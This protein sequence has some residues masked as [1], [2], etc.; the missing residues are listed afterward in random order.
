MPK[1]YVLIVILLFSFC[2]RAQS[3]NTETVEKK[4]ETKTVNASKS[5]ETESAQTKS[6]E[7][8][9]GEKKSDDTKT[10]SPSKSK[11]T[12]PPE[13][14]IPAKIPKIT[15]S[16]TIDGKIDEEVWAKAAVFKDFYQTNPG[17]NIA[18]S[19]PTEARM[20]YDEKHLYIAFKC[21]D[22]KDKIRA[23]VAKRDDV[24]G[25]DNVR[26][27]LDT[28]NDQRRAYILGFNP[29]GIQMDGI[30][31]E[32]RGSDFSVDIVMES[33]GVIEDWGWSVEVKIPFKSLRYTAGK[34]KMWGFNVAR[35]IDRFNDEFD[36]WMPDDRNIS[37]QLIK[38]GRITG[39]DE[40]KYER[41]LEIVPS[42]TVSET[43][44][45][46]RANEVPGGRF[47]NQPIKQDIGVNLKYTITPNITLDAAYNPDFAEIEADAPVVSANQRFP[48][49]FEEKRPFFL[50]GADIFQTPLQVF[51]SRNII[52]PDFAAK[53]TGKVGKTSFGFLAASDNAPGNYE[54]DDRI[55]QF[56]RPRID[57]FLDK[58]ALFGILRVKRDFGK[59]NNIGFTATYRGFPEQRNVL[60]GF[61][62]RFKLNEKT[63]FQFQAVGTNS[64]RCFFDAEFEPLLN[65]LQ[66]QRNREICGGGTFN[67]TTVLGNP[68][69][70]YRTGNGLAYY[71][72]YDYTEKNRGFQI[73][74]GGR[75]KDYR[76]DAGF[77][78]RQNTNYAFA[79]FRLSTE[80]KPKA[81][82][83][84]ANWFNNVSVNYDWQG[85]S[86]GAEW[87]SNLSFTLQ[88]NTRLN[89]NGGIGYERLFEEEFGLKRMPTRPNG[90]AFFGN[91]E[92]STTNGWLSANF[93]KQI[94][95]KISVGVFAGTIFNAYD[96]DFGA[97]ERFPRV[98]SAFA[99]YLVEE[100]RRR[101][102]GLS[103]LSEPGLDPG[104]GQQ[105][106]FGFE[107]ELKPINPLRMSLEYNKS[108]LVR[109]DTGRI[110][111]DA[112][113]VT[114]RS[115]YQFT[116]F[117]F[118]RTRL[119][120]DSISSNVKGQLLFG[121]NPSPGTAFYAGYN[122]DFNYRGFNPF[123]GNLEP[124]IARNG[125]TFFIRASYLFRKSF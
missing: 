56:V 99:A 50:E 70:N 39:L 37:G 113:I 61:D 66:T 2:I 30:Q 23:T 82:I 103:S 94:N 51:Y 59:E 75:S 74:V 36:S 26:V 47:V 69:Q 22:E 29:Y 116:R 117:I 14:L 8:M 96:F 72:N 118:A 21:W 63:V 10:V 52:D 122:D 95:K 4:G 79:G 76:A 33:K 60:G 24:F 98:S 87:G 53:L 15:L 84:R 109:N 38:H 12:I 106:D 6:V 111:F 102:L 35:N 120:Y 81:T 65:S 85:R 92:R 3:G 105:Y 119:D 49:F 107:I 89:F 123:T 124:G 91:S 18:P 20:M 90:G 67:G 86:Q 34:G 28:Y 71:A 100:E 7:K 19:K 93:S 32:G 101:R 45:R 25:E 58:N 5:V 13:K 27:W 104:T 77:T 108:R 16:P 112:N 121:W 83:I 44:R 114:L 31:T 62:G 46:F 40:I 125:R 57:E 48:I 42:I 110:A 73:E 88:N 115:T 55:N 68:Y 11:I 80:T 1:L 78:R 41:T 64:R 43:G 97:G 54:D 17:D 9:S